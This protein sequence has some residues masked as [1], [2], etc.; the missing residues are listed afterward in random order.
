MGVTQILAQDIHFSQPDADP[1]LL[2]PAYAGFFD[3]RGRFGVI[4]RNQWATISQ[5]FQTY[6]LTGEIALWRN[7]MGTRGLS[8]GTTM[9]N[10]H[11]GS[12]N[13]GSTSAH[14]ALA[15][16]TAL[17]R[18]GN[19]ILSFGIDAG[20]CHSGFD[21][22][23]ALVE[24]PAERFD[25]L[26]TSYP[27]IGAGLAWY[28][29]A[30]NNFGIRA[31]LSVRN[32]NQPNVTYSGLNDAILHRRLTLFTR[33]EWRRWSDLSLMPVL[34][35]QRQG[36]YQELVYG[37][38]LKWYLQEGGQHEVSLKSGVAFR[39]AD[40]LIANLVMEYDAL[41]FTFCYDANISDLVAAS[42]SIGA[43][44]IGLVYCLARGKKRTKAIKCPVF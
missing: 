7:D 38:D 13:Y 29:Q 16:Y 24:N 21:P 6:A 19:N 42:G 17:N 27:L 34:M 3:G 8:L 23:N 10:D 36:E 28:F 12:L 26:G 41:I 25:I 39:Q 11:A 15:F 22:G 33:A 32:I 5:P 4:Y 31:G 14:M 2:N 35:F 18:Y 30:A 43:F 9:F 37:A 44:E 1:L 40:A 20:Y